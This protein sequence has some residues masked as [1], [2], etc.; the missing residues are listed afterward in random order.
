[1]I[2]IRDLISSIKN[3]PSENGFK[4][5][6]NVIPSKVEEMLNKIKQLELV[7]RESY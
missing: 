3:I 4:N 6:E 2:D 7:L 5:I 1:M